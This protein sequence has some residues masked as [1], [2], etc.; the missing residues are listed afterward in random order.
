MEI[1]Q[2]LIFKATGLGPLIQLLFILNQIQARSNTYF[3]ATPIMDP[4][5][6]LK[7]YDCYCSKRQGNSEQ[8]PHVDGAA[9]EGATA[10]NP[11]EFRGTSGPKD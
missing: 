5:D 11:R 4:V 7:N 9:A 6:I 8:R 10:R 3:R 1:A 2:Y